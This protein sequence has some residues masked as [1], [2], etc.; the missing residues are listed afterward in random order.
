[1]IYSHLL[2][3]ILLKP[4]IIIHMVVDKAKGILKLYLHCGFTNITVVEPC[5]GEPSDS[6]LV[7][8][9]A[10]KTRNVKALDINIQ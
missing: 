7:A 9:D 8:I 5:L 6:C 2:G 4:F 10:D 1:M 3:E